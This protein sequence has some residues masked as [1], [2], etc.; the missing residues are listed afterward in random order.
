[1]LV[2]H[3][4]GERIELADP[5]RARKYRS[6]MRLAGVPALLDA[7]RAEVDVLGVRLAIK[8]RR[9]QAPLCLSQIK[10]GHI[11]DAVRRGVG[12]KEYALPS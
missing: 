9:K 11:C 1:M 8:L 3:D 6:R 2:K 5:G 4:A 12:G 7:I 10:S